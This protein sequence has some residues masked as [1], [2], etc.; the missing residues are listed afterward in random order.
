MEYPRVLVALFTALV[1]GNGVNVPPIPAPPPPPLPPPPFD[2]VGRAI[3]AV[4]LPVPHPDEISVALALR[5]KCAEW[6]GQALPLAMAVLSE[7]AVKEGRGERLAE[8]TPD[9]EA[10]LVAEG[11]S[12][13]PREWEDSVVVVGEALCEV[14]EYRVVLA[15]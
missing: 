15:V 2:P 14:L 3:E 6:L 4:P 13:D 7:V 12:D 8:S 10:T 5:V 9:T 11:L 1:V